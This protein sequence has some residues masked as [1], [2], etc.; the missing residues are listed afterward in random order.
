MCR[1]VFKNTALRIASKLDNPD[2]NVEINKT[3]PREGAFVVTV[4]GV[5]TPI[6]ELLSLQTPFAELKNLNVD[7]VVKKV[8]AI[9]ENS[10]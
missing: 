7:S 9:I 3:Y 6:V 10:T 4:D 1:T 5:T 8:M 2:V